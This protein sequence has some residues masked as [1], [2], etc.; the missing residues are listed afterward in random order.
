[1]SDE[2]RLSTTSINGVGARL[3]LFGRY[4]V[5]PSLTTTSGTAIVTVFDPL[6]SGRCGMT[7]NLQVVWCVGTPRCSPLATAPYE[8]TVPF[9]MYPC[10]VSGAHLLPTPGPR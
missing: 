6:V 10:S 5:R 4:R 8:K 9:V 3:C 2:W 7:S 1:M